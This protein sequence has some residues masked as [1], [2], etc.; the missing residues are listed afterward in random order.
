MVPSP[1]WE[2]NSRS[3]TQEFPNILWNPTVHYRVRKSPP[4]FPILNQT[5]PVRKPHPVSLRCILILFSNLR[6]G[7]TS[8]LCALVVSP[9]RA[10]CPVH[11]VLPY[12][13]I[14]IIFVEEYNLWSSS[15]ALYD[16]GS[17]GIQATFILIQQ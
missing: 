9:T 15:L 1:F 16:I 8:G 11:L 17:N 2:A 10:T 14:L 4:L 12:L 7:L 6:I 3:V 13:V 5:N